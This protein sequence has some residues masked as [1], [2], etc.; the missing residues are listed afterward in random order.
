VVQSNLLAYY[1]SVVDDH[2]AEIDGLVLFVAIVDV[3]NSLAR[4]AVD[5]GSILPSFSVLSNALI[6]NCLADGPYCQ[7]EFVQSESAFLDIKQ[8]RHPYI[9]TPPY[10]CSHH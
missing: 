6:L 5:Q 8:S 10:R 2:F 3:L 1:V 9:K 4:S 7:P